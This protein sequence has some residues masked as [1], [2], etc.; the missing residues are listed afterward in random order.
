MKGG[1]IWCV[2]VSCE[3]R[4]RTCVLTSHAEPLSVRL[5]FQC[6]TAPDILCSGPTKQSVRLV[7]RDW[8]GDAA[9][10]N[11]KVRRIQCILRCERN[12]TLCYHRF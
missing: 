3:L 11:E 1:G 10:N 9:P 7:L 8:W 2:E 4:Q 6:P 12:D 5:T